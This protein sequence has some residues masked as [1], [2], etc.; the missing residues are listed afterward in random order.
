MP[1]LELR[2]LA[3]DNLVLEAMAGT[4]LGD[5]I[6]ETLRKIVRVNV[7]RCVV[8]DRGSGARLYLGGGR[9]NYS[10]LLELREGRVNGRAGQLCIRR[11]DS[12]G[13]ACICRWGSM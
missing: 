4:V 9:R 8:G 13:D 7:D 11:R 5:Q 10:Y 3:L 2:A 1:V 6:E 12:G